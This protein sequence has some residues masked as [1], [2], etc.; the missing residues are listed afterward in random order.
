MSLCYD[1]Q[2]WTMITLTSVA[3]SLSVGLITLAYGQLET[4]IGTEIQCTT[5]LQGGAV[6]I[7]L[8]CHGHTQ[9]IRV[10]LG[11]GY[12]ID[13]QTAN[14]MYLVPSTDT[15]E[16]MKQKGINLNYTLGAR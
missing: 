7:D 4:E 8:T 13:T 15:I 16:I 5:W 10:F 1:F 9:T 3:I 14:E 6:I 12:L 2:K 11:Y